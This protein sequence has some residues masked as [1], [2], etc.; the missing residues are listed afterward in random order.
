M[1]FV[2]A[3]CAILGAPIYVLAPVSI[4]VGYVAGC[5]KERL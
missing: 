2:N 3:L 4:A 5:I 1:E